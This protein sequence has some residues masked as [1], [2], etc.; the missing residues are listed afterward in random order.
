[1]ENSC[2]K[3]YKPSSKNWVLASRR[4][5]FRR[6]SALIPANAGLFHYA[7]NNPV[8]YIDPDGRVTKFQNKIRNIYQNGYAP[9]D[10]NAMDRMVKV[11]FFDNQGFTKTHNLNPTQ[12]TEENR[13]NWFL[14][15]TPET[16][17]D[18][19]G[20]GFFKGMQFIYNN[21]TGEIVVDAINKGTYDYKSP[22]GGFDNFPIL[23]HSSYDID[24]WEKWGTGGP[25]KKE[26]VVMSNEL[27]SQIDSILLDFESGKIKKKEAQERIINILPTRTMPPK[28]NPGVEE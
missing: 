24:T 13:K 22:Y 21:E 23:S 18:Y 15:K 11:G 3:K 17:V 14:L 2:R 26:D 9:P 1:M 6:N 5:G 7:G 20:K 28:M 8:R 4:I 19:R 16:N 27:W 12:N 10:K 25:D